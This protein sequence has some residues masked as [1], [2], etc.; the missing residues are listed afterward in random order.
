MDRCIKCGCLLSASADSATLC[1]KCAK[2][3]QEIFV[4]DCKSPAF[5]FERYEGI[6]KR[7]WFAGMALQ[8]L[9]AN[10]EFG[11]LDGSTLANYAFRQADE[12]I[13]RGAL[14]EQ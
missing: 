8:G 9:S 10:P 5:P 6:T 13:K 4:G 1:A 2:L 7:E 14:Y 3:K 12:M 11:A